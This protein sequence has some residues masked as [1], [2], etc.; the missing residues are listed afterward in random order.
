MSNTPS[1]LLASQPNVQFTSIVTSGDAFPNG[2]LFA[3]NPDGMAAFDNGDG[4]ITVLIN[5]EYG[6]TSGI[7]RDHGSKGAFVDRLVIDKATLEVISSDDLIK[8]VYRWDD[9]A[10]A[11]VVGT[12]AFARLCS[13][14]LPAPTAFYNEATGLG[15][16]ARIYTIGE[17]AGS[18]GRAFAITLEDG[19]AFEL[20][21][22][23]NMNF[24][25]IVANPF[26]QD[27]TIVAMTDDAS[28]GQVHFYIGQKQSSG[29]EIEKAGLTG[30]DFYGLKVTE[31]LSEI[32]ATPA[33]G[34][35][36]LQEIGP[37]GDVSNM[38]GD[39]IE[40]ESDAEGVTGF[41]KPEDIAWDPDNPD[42]LY[43]V[44]TNTLIGNSRLYKL[45]FTDIANPAA[46]GTIEAVLTGNEGHHKLDNLTVSNG[47]IILQE[48]P[49]DNEALAKVWEYDTAT[50]TLTLLAQPDPNLFVLGGNG[51]I[52]QD[53]ESSGVID[54][55]ALLGDSD[56]RAY[57][58]N[59]QVDTPTTDPRV[60]D[61]GQ[62]MVMYIHDGAANTA[63][64]L[65]AAQATLD[66]GVEDGPYVV[67]ADNLL[68]GY[69]DADSDA[70]SVSNLSADVGTVVNNQDGTF[71]ITVAPD[72]NGTVNLSYN[73]VDGKGG[74]TPASQSF[75]LAAINDAP[76]ANS[77]SY[78]VITGQTLVVPDGAT[79]ILSNDTDIDG[80][81]LI[82][83]FSTGPANGSL[84]LNS[85]GSFSYVPSA[86]FV[87]TDTFTYLASD[88]AADSPAATVTI[89]VRS[90]GVTIEG[91]S[92]A[93]IISPSQTVAGQPLPGAGDDTI[94]G[95]GGNDQLDGGAGGDRLEGGLGNDIYSVDNGGDRL[96]ELSGQ[97]VDTVKSS[98]SYTLPSEVERLQLGGTLAIDGTGNALA[99]VITGNSQANRLYGLDGD[100]RLSG[101][102]GADW[103]DGGA[104][105]DTLLG[106][107]GSDT[108]YGGVGS[109]RLT[110]GAGSDVLTGGLDADTFI[111][112]ATSDSRASLTDRITDFSGL[113]AD[114]IDLTRIDANTG[115]SGDQAF[116]FIGSSAFSGGGPKGAGAGQ[117]RVEVV[118][119]DTRITGDLN[120]DGAADFM[121][122]LSNFIGLQASDFI[123]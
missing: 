10:D 117:L 70:M 26:A 118:G 25:N 22:L 114:K 8:S 87:G 95:R 2:E 98:V 41:L 35:F 45:T 83:S 90:S 80:P 46:G 34:T 1:Y 15:S 53:E 3:G 57:L 88:G 91:T 59:M 73:V 93:D 18:T 102:G 19:I 20:P 94:F 17:E 76:I 32:N 112:L 13:G 82:A 63:P 40:A 44:T 86:G 109:D 122:T 107:G 66:G 33:N 27:Q 77:D 54:V 52:N 104:G 30:G 12:T 37:G 39:D 115:L 68:T 29:T 85:D 103:L 24:E 108:L 123:L 84:T 75:S 120:G 5:H 49:G 28:G 97:G 121:I 116:T 71:T 105:S 42:V 81:A 110:G 96:V 58:V 100:D 9:V 56:T 99:N 60:V 21:F 72:Y 14:D 6:S 51:Y 7:V 67:S 61:G 92:A 38:I 106:V 69:T 65:T 31:V 36:T 89:T 111:F 119:S 55:T 43:F 78:L 16:N 4:T 113:E 64:A 47:K 50:D 101:L 11:Y 74:A 62:L 23:G 79:D 48:D